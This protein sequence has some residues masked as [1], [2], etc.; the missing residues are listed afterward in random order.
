MKKRQDKHACQPRTIQAPRDASAETPG[1]SAASGAGRPSSVDSSTPSSTTTSQPLR[2]SVRCFCAR[3]ASASPSR[4]VPW[5]SVASVF[6]HYPQPPI[7]FNAVPL[8]LA[9]TYLLA[10]R[11]H[12]CS[13]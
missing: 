11:S 3:V 1:A 12:H 7:G 9:R 6:R 13:D 2:I 10:R 4:S 5:T 8:A